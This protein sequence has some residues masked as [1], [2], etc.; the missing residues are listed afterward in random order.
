MPFCECSGGCRHESD[1]LDGDSAL[2]DSS[3]GGL[4]GTAEHINHVSNST[5]SIEG[6]TERDV[7]GQR[8]GRKCS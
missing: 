5:H 2:R 1:R 6:I 3:D 4:E 8:Y 7:C